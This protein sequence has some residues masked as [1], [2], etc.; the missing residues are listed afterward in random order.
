VNDIVLLYILINLRKFT[1]SAV[2]NVADEFQVKPT[3]TE[4]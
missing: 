2:E 1:K 3:S 4:A